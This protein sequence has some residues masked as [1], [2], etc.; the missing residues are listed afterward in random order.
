ARRLPETQQLPQDCPR[1]A[2][3]I[4]PDGSLAAAWE[5]GVCT[6]TPMEAERISDFIRQGKEIWCHDLKSVL[7]RLDSLG[8]TQGTFAFDTALD[9]YDLIPAQSEDPVSKLATYFLAMDVSDEHAAG[10]DRA[11]YF[12]FPILEKELEKQDMLS[13]YRDME[14][15]LCTVLYNM[16]KTG[17]AI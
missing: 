1:F 6:V 10:C 16:E 5:D 3:Y 14:F 7:H 2:L 12:L 8:L 4:A 11:I 9:A 15:P 17:V 13:L